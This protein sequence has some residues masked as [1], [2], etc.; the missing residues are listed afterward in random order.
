MTPEYPFT[1]L[2]KIIGYGIAATYALWVFYLAV[3]NLKRAKDAGNLRPIAL[4]L[5]SPILVVGIVIDWL[6]NWVVFTVV[7]LDFP[8]SAGELVTGRLKRYV[9]DEPDTWRASLAFWFA[10]ELLDAFDPSGKHI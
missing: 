3:M 6:V 10:D 8:E 2:L 4:W 9:R 5:G 7:C 1:D